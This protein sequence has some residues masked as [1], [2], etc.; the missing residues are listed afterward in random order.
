MSPLEQTAAQLFEAA[1][2]AAQLGESAPDWTVLIAPEG[3]VTVVTE[4]G[5]SLDAIAGERGAQA[6]FRISRGRDAVRVE[7]R[8]G[9]R[10]CVIEER[11]HPSPH[12]FAPPA[13]GR[14]ERE[15]VFDMPHANR[16]VENNAHD[17]EPQSGIGSA[18]RAGE[19]RRR[20]YQSAPLAL[21]DGPHRIAELA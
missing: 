2:T 7:G 9:R 21:I 8:A 20:A 6:A 1:E 13:L 11:R 17:I 12:H 4:P 18:A 16:L 5:W 3:A 10:R 19:C 14:R 15:D